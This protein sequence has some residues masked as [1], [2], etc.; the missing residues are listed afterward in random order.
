MD[1]IF[2]PGHRTF[3]GAITTNAEPLHFQ[4]AVKIKAW[5]DAMNKEIDSLEIKKTWDIV[6]LPPNKI[7]IGSQWVYKTKYNADGTV[8]RYK[9]RLVALGNKQEGEDCNDTFAHVVKMTT[10]RTI[11]RL[12]AAN[13][14]EVYRNGRQ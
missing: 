7:A 8:E 1:E 4:E 11:L 13:Q 2:S 9:T 14:W 3:L 5:N 12:V 6:D 10:I